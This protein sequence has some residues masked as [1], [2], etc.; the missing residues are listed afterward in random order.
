[1]DDDQGSEVE[2][3]RQERQER[4]ERQE[5]DLGRA[6][7]FEVMDKDVAQSS[8]ETDWLAADYD[9]SHD[10]LLTA[11]LNMVVAETEEGEEERQG[12]GQRQGQGHPQ[13]RVGSGGGGGGTEVDDLQ[14]G[15]MMS[16]SCSSPSRDDDLPY[17]TE[18]PFF[19]SS[20]SLP[21]AEGTSPV[22]SPSAIASR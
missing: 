22:G 5:E 1:V 15:M 4:R 18:V 2:V 10:L 19:Q 17:F 8:M 14:D 12:Q 21:A 13:A 3:E 6:P 16:P 20:S 7:A 11:E 9:E